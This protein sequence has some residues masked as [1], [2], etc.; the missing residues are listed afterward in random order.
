MLSAQIR[1]TGHKLEQGRF[2]LTTRKHFCPEAVESPPWR[3]PN[4]LDV[5]LGTLIGVALLEQGVGQMPPQVP[6]SL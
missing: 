6:S 3:A 4:S 2:C 1:G 5:V